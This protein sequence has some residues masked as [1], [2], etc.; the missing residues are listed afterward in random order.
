M[1]RAELD[2]VQLASLLD[3]KLNDI[4][5]EL[6]NQYFVT[7]IL[8]GQWL[9][10][11]LVA[12]DRGL[13][14]IRCTAHGGEVAKYDPSAWDKDSSDEDQFL[15]HV[16]RHPTLLPSPAFFYILLTIYHTSPTLLHIPSL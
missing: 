9:A 7:A 10:E 12:P 1:S 14:H 11:M 13:E 5:Q 15:A 3:K 4:A 16:Y 6:V 2:R 8:A